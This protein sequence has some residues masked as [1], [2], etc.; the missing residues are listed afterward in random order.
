[1]SEK[2]TEVK[3][4][5]YQKL[6]LVRQMAEAIVKNKKGYG[7]T[8]VSEDEILAKV[9]AGM[10]KYGLSLIPNITPNTTK[11]T[12]YSYKKIKVLK[13]GETKEET[14]N[15]ILVQ[16]DMTWTWVNNDNPDEQIIVT[17]TLTGQQ[18]DASQCFGSGLSYTTRYFLLKYFN[19]ATVEDD[20]DE[21]RSKQ[22]EA[23]KQAE[24]V[25]VKE[26]IKKIDSLAKTITTERPELKDSLIALI[27]KNN[28]KNN[29]PS[30]NYFEIDNQVTAS[31]V[32]TSIKELAKENKIN[33]NE[34]KV[35]E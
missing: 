32:L 35:E 33:E 10:N 2:T 1:M 28:K 14:V 29:K 31:K 26:I 24:T 5:I 27:M 13:D 21:W 30:A 18:S 17:W 12:P 11:V 16:A 20:V 4:N 6:A 19:I 9:T 34:K 3:L 25:V 15:E 8:Y 7:Y 22:Q 23:E